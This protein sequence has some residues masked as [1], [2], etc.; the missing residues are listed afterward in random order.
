MFVNPSDFNKNQIEKFQHG[1]ASFFRG[2]N[3]NDKNVSIPKIEYNDFLFL[4]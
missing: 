2:V 4:V 1:Q 3:M